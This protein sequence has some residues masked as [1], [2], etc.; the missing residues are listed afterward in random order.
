MLHMYKMAKVS[1]AVEIWDP[2][3]CNNCSCNLFS[4][5]ESDKYYIKIFSQPPRRNLTAGIL[6]DKRILPWAGL[7]F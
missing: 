6:V 4:I 5:K 3:L 7:L 2:L 1:N